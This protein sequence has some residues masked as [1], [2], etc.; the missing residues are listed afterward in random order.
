MTPSTIALRSWD[1][2]DLSLLERLVGEPAMTHHLGGPETSVRIRR[3]HQRYLATKDRPDGRMYVVVVG[4]DR[5]AAG[6]VGYWEHA[7]H[8]ET[9]WE[10]GWSVL[11]EYQGQGVATVAT[12]LILAEVRAGRRRCVHAFPSVDNAASN[13]VCRKAGFALVGPCDVEYPPGTMLRSNDWEI[14]LR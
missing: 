14:D 5:V 4:E 1:D 13:A 7:W 9:V 3:R 10:M 6:S 12:R 11:P 2:G 8:G